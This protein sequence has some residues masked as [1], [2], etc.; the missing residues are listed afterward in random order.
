MTPREHL[1]EKEIQI[2]EQVWQGLTNREIG[3]LMGP[4]S[5]SSRIICAAHSTSWEYGLAW[6][7]QC[8]WPATGEEIGPVC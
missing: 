3:R 4:P 2:A 7:W 8:M 5:R 1:T 6:N